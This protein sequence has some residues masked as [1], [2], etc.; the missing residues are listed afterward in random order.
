[1]NEEAYASDPTESYAQGRWRVE[2]YATLGST[3]DLA[4]QRA[5]VGD[6]G[7]LWVVADQQT[8][9]RGR[10]GRPW[11]SPSGNLYASALVIDPCAPAA[12]AQIG[13]VAG[14]AAQRAVAD[15]GLEAE[16][17][18]PNDLVV[19]G[20]KLAGLLVEGVT[21]PGRRL[22]AVVG[23]GVNVV[24]SP[25]GLP[26]PT[27]SLASALGAPSSARAL[28]DRLVLRFDEALAAWARGAG[29]ASIR[30]AWL[31]AAA[32]LGGPIRVA[33]AHG[34]RDGLFEG[35]DEQGR[36]RLKRDGVVETIESAD[37]TLISTAAG[38]TWT[39]GKVTSP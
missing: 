13:F 29:F 18:W 22:A 25:D 34:A 36:L 16:L 33:N 38:A 26:Y 12:A 35:L 15:L 6:G 32:N 23:I 17:K 39:P 1:L 31:A 10:Q 28:L 19:G 4:R 24:S 20:A 2:R 21:P 30:G 14:V 27:A 3:N 11:S 8:A 7:W 37:I 5:L 9:G